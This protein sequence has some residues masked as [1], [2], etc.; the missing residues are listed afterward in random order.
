MSLLG[1]QQFCRLAYLPVSS[2]FFRPKR[3]GRVTRK[4]GSMLGSGFRVQMDLK[5]ANRNRA[6]VNCGAS[7]VEDLTLLVASYRS[8]SH[9][10]RRG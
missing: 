7:L 5:E 3:S 9:Q 2:H 1:F 4:P 6:L 8:E 10:C